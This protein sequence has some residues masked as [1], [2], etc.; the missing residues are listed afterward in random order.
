VWILL[1]KGEKYTWEEIKRQNVEQKL[2][3]R[4]SRDCPTWG[5]I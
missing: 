5:C 4:P 1:R 3:K 2:K